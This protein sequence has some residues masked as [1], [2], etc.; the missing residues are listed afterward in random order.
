MMRIYDL[1]KRNVLMLE[2]EILIQLGRRTEN[3]W[4]RR[5]QVLH[6]VG[7]EDWNRKKLFYQELLRPDW[8]S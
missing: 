7:S 8:S 1:A 2:K 5:W 6:V 3:G 4:V